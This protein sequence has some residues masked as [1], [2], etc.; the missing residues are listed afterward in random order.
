M[1]GPYEEPGPTRDEVNAWSGPAVLEFGADWCGY[2][3]GAQPLI[4]SALGGFPD[5]RH[6][7]V[8]DG[9]GKRL[10]RSFAVKLWPTLVFLKD[11]QE[12]ARAVRPTDVEEVRRGLV[13]TG[14]A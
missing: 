4:L 12:V 5:V 2:C 8:A 1:N 3:Q 6:V 10:G 9:K 13:A 11:G 14:A 7:K